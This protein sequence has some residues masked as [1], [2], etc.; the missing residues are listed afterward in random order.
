MHFTLFV[1]KLSFLIRS[2]ATIGCAEL[3]VLHS[4]F[5]VSFGFAEAFLF[6]NLQSRFHKLSKQLC[7]AF[8]SQEGGIDTD[9]VGTAITPSRF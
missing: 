4:S 5:F 2:K 6:L 8:Q 1:V 7:C 9:V 3:K